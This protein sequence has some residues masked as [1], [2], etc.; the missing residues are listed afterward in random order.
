MQKRWKDKQHYFGG[1]LV[2]NRLKYLSL[3]IIVVLLLSSAVLAQPVKEYVLKL[4][5]YPVLVRGE[6]Y[7]DEK[8]PFLNYNG[9]TYVPLRAISELLDVEIEW[10]ETLRRVEIGK[11][12][13]DPEVNLETVITKDP[14]SMAVDT[15]YFMG[16]YILEKLHDKY[17]ETNIRLSADG[18]LEM[19]NKSFKL[20][21]IVDEQNII[22]FSVKPLVDAKI[23]TLVELNTGE[24]HPLELK[25]NESEYDLHFT[26]V[27]L[28]TSLAKDGIT[29]VLQ[30]I[31]RVE[32]PSNGEQFEI[33]IYFNIANDSERALRS[34]RLGPATGSLFYILEEKIY[35][36][37]FNAGGYGHIGDATSWVYPGQSRSVGY[38]KY[39]HSPVSIEQILWTG[40]F[41]DDQTEIELGPWEN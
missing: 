36:E 40:T 18:F 24:I 3:T 21:G 25:S 41:A 26:P 27:S 17:P 12:E 39:F 35:E 33:N 38:K 7:V 4:V 6:E 10:N 11:A 29:V 8:N 28:G 5:D 23:I 15:Y 34:G 14:F 20:P 30:K 37:E 19:A 1:A 31:E 22:R 16:R 32:Q 13:D 2:L 9:T